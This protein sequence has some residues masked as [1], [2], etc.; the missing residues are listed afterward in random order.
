VYVKGFVSIDGDDYVI[1][2]TTNRKK[3]KSGDYN[4][5]PE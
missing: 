2:R 4:V 1:E 5:L 3:T